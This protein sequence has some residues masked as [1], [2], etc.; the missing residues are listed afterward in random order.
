MDLGEIFL[1]QSPTK[2]N[3]MVWRKK[4][5][6]KYEEI[7]FFFICY[8]WFEFWILNILAIT[9]PINDRLSYYLTM[10]NKKVR[11]EE[12]RFFLICYFWFEFWIS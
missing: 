12:I 1:P 4:K 8:F 6:T 10:V 5:Q 3:N 9:N 2:R 11:G 7:R